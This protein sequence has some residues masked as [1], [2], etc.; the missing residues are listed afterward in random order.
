[1]AGGELRDPDALAE[2]K[3]FFAENKLPKRGVRLGIAMN[4]IGVRTLEIVGID[5]PKQLANAIRFRAQDALP[6]PIDEAVL[7]YQVLAESTN[8]EGASVRKIL[9]VLA[10]RDLVDR[11]VGACRK[12][13]ISLVG[14]D[15][16][17]FA[18]LWRW[19][20]LVKKVSR[21]VRRWSP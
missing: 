10:Y 12:A 18:L 20:R 5:D 1:M 17:A 4:R 11:Y 2:P 3:E 13:G 6:I 9:L 7:D 16:E 8:D 14:I 21:Q 19:R 15:L